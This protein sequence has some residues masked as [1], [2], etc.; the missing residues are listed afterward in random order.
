MNTNSLRKFDLKKTNMKGKDGACYIRCYP[1]L[2]YY[3]VHSASNIRKPKS[4]FLEVMLSDT[5]EW[6]RSI[7]VIEN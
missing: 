4:V 1:P 5:K 3:K 6:Y 2:E 7:M